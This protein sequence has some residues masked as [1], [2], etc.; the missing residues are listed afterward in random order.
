MRKRRIRK[1]STALGV[2]LVATGGLASEAQAV[3]I[4]IFGTSDLY[5]SNLY[6][7][8][9]Q[10]LYNATSP[11][12]VSGDTLSYTSVGTGR[13]LTS[14]QNGYADLVLVHSPPLEKNFVTG[15]YSYEPLGRSLLYNDYV[16]VGPTSDPAGVAANAPHDGVKAYTVIA[17]RGASN[18]DVT[19]VSRNDA[20]GTNVQEETMWGQ[21][22]LPNV[23]AAQNGGSVPNLFQPSVA[24]GSTVYP[25]WYVRQKA[26]SGFQTQGANLISTSTCAAAFA[27]DGG[28]YTMTDRGTLV[29]QQSL[30]QATGLTILSQS[31]MAGTTGGVTEL[32]NPFHA[33]IVTP[34]NPKPGSA[35]VYPSGVTPNVTAATRFV[36]FL[37]GATGASGATGH[38]TY[39]PEFQ[40]ELSTYLAPSGTTPIFNS[41]AFPAV[42][43]PV[44][45][46]K[47][48]PHSV[49]HSSLQTVSAKV[50]YVPESLDGGSP[51]TG[52]PYKINMSTDNGTT[53]TTVTA[54]VYTGSLSTTSGAVKATATMPATVGTT[55]KLQLSTPVY[56]DSV[57]G[58]STQFSPHENNVDLGSFITS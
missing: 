41:D 49:L 6:Q 48:S 9:M 46:P 54:G 34:I 26:G 28:C 31:N 15:G 18:G 12:F 36:N 58:F 30:G 53:W 32:I 27:P 35:G 4:R 40:N 25:T 44:P 22:G 10:T 24:A 42:I 3:T 57:D 5:D 19:F 11:F 14:A 51:I 1:V 47:G 52:I 23:Q 13:A 55:V 43:A 56:N 2:A 37:T 20:S 39:T 29:Y 7:A 38:Q 8:K 50:I 33:Y 21:T 45:T 17:Q 16:I